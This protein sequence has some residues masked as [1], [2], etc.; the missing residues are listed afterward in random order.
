MAGSAKK[1]YC[2]AF[3]QIKAALEKGKN[4]VMISE[5]D[6][7]FYSTFGYIFKMACEEGIP[8]QLIP[9]IPAFI[10]AGTLGVRPLAEKKYGH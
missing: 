4:V 2:E 1:Y 5:G 6:L 9:G 10:A 8:C 7:L 3:G